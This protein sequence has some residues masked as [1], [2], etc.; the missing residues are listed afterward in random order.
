MEVR[1]C[2]SGISE[3]RYSDISSFREVYISSSR[4]AVNS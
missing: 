2:G 4:D 1:V 3:Y